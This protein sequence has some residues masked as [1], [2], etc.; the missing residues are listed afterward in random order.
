[1]GRSSKICKEE[2][3]ANAIAIR[4]ARAYS[5]KDNVAFCGYHGWHDWYLSANLNN[6]NNLNKHLLKGIKI[7]GVPNNL[8]NTAFPFEYN[9]LNN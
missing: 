4:I 1:M 6:K 5:K 9:K 2:G 7:S 3:E 8:K